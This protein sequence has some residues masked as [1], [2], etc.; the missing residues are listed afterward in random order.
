MYS[1]FNVIYFK[2][3]TDILMILFMC[4]KNNSKIPIKFIKKK[5]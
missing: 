2:D 4:I 1:S 5:R 3:E